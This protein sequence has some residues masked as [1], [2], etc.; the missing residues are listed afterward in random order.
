MNDEL[1]TDL[2]KLFAESYE[3]FPEQAFTAN[4]KNTIESK[5]RK[6]KSIKIIA[7][8]FFF[9]LLGMFFQDIN[10]VILDIEQTAHQQFTEDNLGWFD[11]FNTHVDLFP[12]SFYKLSLSLM[13]LVTM[14]VGIIVTL[15][16]VIITYAENN[17]LFSKS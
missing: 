15:S 7:A 16:W 10:T 6:K 14:L 1:D 8:C 4:I 12:E 2:K 9:L 17:D 3:A 11:A 5:E 13:G